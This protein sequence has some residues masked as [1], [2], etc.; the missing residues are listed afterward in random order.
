MDFDDRSTKTDSIRSCEAVRWLAYEHMI[1]FLE[2]KKLTSKQL[3]KVE[4]LAKI[5]FDVN[6]YEFNQMRNYLQNRS[7]EEAHQ[8]GS[9]GL[10]AK[11][12]KKQSDVTCE[13]AQCRALKDYFLKT[14]NDM[15]L[16]CQGGEENE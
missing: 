3:R 16:R 2:K 1:R 4:R 13:C 10:R 15:L 7:C 11:E 14:M 6:L 5:V 8:R 9:F 12:Q